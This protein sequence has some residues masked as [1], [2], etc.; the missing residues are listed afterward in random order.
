MEEGAR[1][2]FVYI[3]EAHATDE[4][5]F[6]GINDTVKQHRNMEDRLASARLLQ[7]S[8][9]MHPAMHVVL[10]SQDNTFNKTFPSW[11]FRYY[12]ID[13]GGIVRVKAM[14]EGENSDCASLNQLVDWLKGRYGPL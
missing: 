14:P 7:S 2:V 4:W 6:P 8:F 9:P 5:P 10:D 12:V 11:P 1:F 13:S 3:Q